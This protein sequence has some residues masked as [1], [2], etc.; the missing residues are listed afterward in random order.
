M[1]DDFDPQLADRFR[2]LERV[3]V[4]TTWSPAD[5]AAVAV[6]STRRGRGVVLAAA[7][8]VVAIALI[9]VAV[10][11]RDR[12][13]S[14]AGP[15][16]TATT[17]IAPASSSSTVTTQPAAP[18]PE[19]DWQM[20]RPEGSIASS[21]VDAVV[22]GPNGFVATGM[23][24][25]DGKNWG[26]VWHS[27]DGV[28]WTEPA[29]DVFGAR[30]VGV[31]V[32]TPTAYFVIAGPN[33]DRAD[34]PTGTSLFHSLD[35]EDW[36]PVA[37]ADGLQLLGAAGD[38]LVAVWTE[39]MPASDGVDPNTTVPMP[40]TEVRVSFDGINWAPAMFT[41]GA[42]DVTVFGWTIAAGGRTYLN[43]EVD[44]EL[45]IW[46][47]MDGLEWHRLPAPPQGVLASFG[48]SPAIVLNPG[49]QECRQELVFPT[50]S[51]GQ[52]QDGAWKEFEAAEW[53]CGAVASIW[54]WDGASWVKV[55]A[56]GP[57]PSPV[58]GTVLHFAGQLIAPV[59]TPDR[60][61]VAATSVDGFSWATAAVQAALPEDGGSPQMAISGVS[62]DVAVFITPGGM[63]EFTSLLIGTVVSEAATQTT[64]VLAI[65][66]FVM[67]GA[68]NELQAAGF[69]V[70]AKEGR[71]Q[72]G[73]KN[74]IQRHLDDGTLPDTVVIQ[75][76]TNAPL[77][78]G[79][80][81]EIL[82]LL[83][84][85]TVVMLTVHADG[86]DYIDANNALIR[87]LPEQYP[88]VKIADWDA[89][90][91]GGTVTLTPDGIHLGQFGPA[92]YVQL[93]LDTL[94]AA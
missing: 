31:P 16:S 61:L 65:G 90:V 14:V 52:F 80:L 59:I 21:N 73:A 28:T 44:A 39:A 12:G 7:A 70:D 81:D 86:I 3:S 83:G 88:N 62:A 53:L 60:T 2:V 34:A 4:P 37:T 85:R 26:R 40:R 75:V 91:D 55:T 67:V 27:T 24:L 78:Q 10:F 64:G 41:E 13:A 76:G 47:S 36:Q 45:V 51:D 82:G 32:A 46:E 42:P 56:A 57:G 93:I 89:L 84:G 58:L 22:S 79:D 71:G 74:A 94:A 63:G 54:R 77:T 69:V 23:G 19:I 68:T 15:S 30:W 5:G 8:S 38:R 92:P 17:I 87:A 48:S 11:T 72:E 1:D 66:E 33:P 43:G 20:V 35:G 18:P 9:G 6:R 50:I 49:L 29:V 25:D